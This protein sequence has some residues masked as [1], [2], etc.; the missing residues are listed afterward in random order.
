MS[1]SEKRIG[2]SIRLIATKMASIRIT[3]ASTAP[4]ITVPRSGDTKTAKASGRICAKIAPE[5]W[6]TL[7]SA[8][9]SRASIASMPAPFRM[10]SGRRSAIQGMAALTS[11][12]ISTGTC[13]TPPTM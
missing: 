6:S 7:A 3:R 13:T 5:T 8:K 11:S 2:P 10:T 9:F 4:G 12:S 1:K